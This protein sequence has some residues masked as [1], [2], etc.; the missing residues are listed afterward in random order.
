ME[1]CGLFSSTAVVGPVLRK[2][3]LAH[4]ATKVR[5]NFEMCDAVLGTNSGAFTWGIKTGEATR[6]L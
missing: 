5:T 2:D 3:E 1:S 6:G 4:L